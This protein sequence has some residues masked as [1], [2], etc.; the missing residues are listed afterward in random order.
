M[1]TV[2]LIG[3]GIMGKPMAFHLLKNGFPLLCNDL[4]E[5]AVKEVAAAG[6]TAAT[7]AQIGETCDVVITILPNGAIVQQVLFGENGV[8]AKLRPGSLV[9]DMSSVTPLEAREC[10]AR[11]SAQGVDFLDAPVSGGEAGARDGTLVFMVGGTQQV[12]NR[13]TP[14][15]NALGK[16]ATLIGESGTGCVAKLANQVIVNMGIAA[17]SEALVLAVKAGA[18]PEKVYQAIRGGLAGSAVLDAK[19]PRMIQ[20]DFVPGGK[21]SI[22][23]KDIGNVMATARALDVPMPLTSELFEIM[24]ALKVQGHMD[25]DHG[26]IVQY[27]EGL[28]GVTV[29][30]KQP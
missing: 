12:F 28:A 5:A 9:I 8:A 23:R 4:N 10:A 25:D 30:K 16:N 6:A 21:L 24:Q 7:L 11:F 18:D 27:F 26:G 3:L 1:Q 22:N 29:A 2:G 17:V 20:R 14:Y 15:F 13:A 19:A